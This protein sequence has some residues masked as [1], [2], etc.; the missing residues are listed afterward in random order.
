[1]LLKYFYDPK[2]AHASYLVGCQATGEAIIIDPGRDIEPYLHEAE[3]NDMRIVAAAETHIHADFVSGSRELAECTGARLYLSDEGDENWKY[4]FLDSVAHQLVKDGDSF[5]VGKVKLAVMHTPGHTPEHISFILTDGGGGA[6]KPMGI[7]TGDFI[8]VGSIGRPDLL[9]KA[10]G[11]GGTAVTGAR[12]MFHSVQRFKALPDYLQVW[13]AHGAGSAC[14]KGLGAIPSTTVG[15]EKLFNPALAYDDEESFIEYLLADQPEPP[16]YFAVMK[17]VNKEGP[18]VLHQM[19][20]PEHLPAARLPQLIESGALVIDTRS[21]GSFAG[22]HI[23]GTINIPADQLSAW[24]GWYADYKNPIYLIIDSKNVPEAVRD[25]IYI[26]IDQVKGYFETAAIETLAETGQRVQSYQ[27]VTPDMIADRIL[28]GEVTVVDVRSQTEWDE[29]HIPG[30]RH[31]MLG[32]LLDRADEIVNG[33]P[34]VVQCQ[35][36]ARSAIGASILQAK[37]AREVINLQGGLRDWAAAGFPIEQ[38][39]GQAAG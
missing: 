2:I 12:Q 3:A 28:K 32:Y 1:M 17:R 19:P 24:A 33:V 21:A 39:V 13:P 31:M 29:G 35:T 8:F 7:F 30:A 14:G 4:Q 26:G 36:G 16:T 5:M 27:V 38:P 25:L 9:E 37:G 20:R 6:D 11:I 23:R 10:A 22:R 34:L 18:A 15:Y